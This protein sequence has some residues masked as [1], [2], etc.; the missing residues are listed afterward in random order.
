MSRGTAGAS[1][2]PL[3]RG[4]GPGRGV[5]VCASTTVDHRTFKK[6]LHCPVA[7]VIERLLAIIG[8]LFIVWHLCFDLV[9]TTSGSMAP[10]LQGTS[11]QNGD[12][13]VIEKVSGWFRAPKR[14]EIHFLEDAEGTPV[15]KRI[16]GLPGE[17][18]SLKRNRIYANGREIRRP[19]ALNSLKYYA[20]GNLKAGQEVDCGKGYFVMGDDSRDSYDSRFLGPVSRQQFRGRVWL[21]IWPP[22]RCGFMKAADAGK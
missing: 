16:V 21:I 11:Y 19:P 22:S 3:L 10:A 1:P 14:W 20:Y 12:R 13:V 15:A 17:K 8:A 5:R 2:S 6:G 7:R 18:I 4:R 9:V